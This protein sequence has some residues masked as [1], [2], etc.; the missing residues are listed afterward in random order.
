MVSLRAGD[1]QSTHRGALLKNTSAA[2]MP[3]PSASY[4]VIELPFLQALSLSDAPRVTPVCLTHAA[5]PSA[6]L[7]PWH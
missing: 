2:A 7:S 1:H 6:Q 4:L 5:L 3:A